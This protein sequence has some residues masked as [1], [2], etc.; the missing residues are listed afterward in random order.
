MSGTRVEGG[1]ER[2]E[3]ICAGGEGGRVRVLREQR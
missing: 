2:D 1:G 3:G